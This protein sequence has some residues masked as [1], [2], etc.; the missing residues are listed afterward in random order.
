MLIPYAQSQIRQID[1]RI[2]FLT[3]NGAS[4]DRIDREKNRRQYLEK[5]IK[6]KETEQ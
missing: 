5:V 3:I 6:Q 2:I 4:E 1:K